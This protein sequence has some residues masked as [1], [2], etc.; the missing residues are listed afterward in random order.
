MPELE[1]VRIDKVLTNILF[2]YNTVM[3]LMWEHN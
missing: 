2:P 3:R 1:N